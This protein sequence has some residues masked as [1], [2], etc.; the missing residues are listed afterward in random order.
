MCSSSYISKVVA[1]L[2]VCLMLFACGSRKS[3]V[4]PSR[5]YC[6]E[7]ATSAKSD[8]KMAEYLAR[9]MQ[10]R[11]D[12]KILVS[13]ATEPDHYYVS[14]HVGDDFGGDYAI[15][16]NKNSCALSARDE[17]IMTWLLYQFIK[18]EG[19]AHG[20]RVDDLPPSILPDHDTVYT[21]PFE[22]RDI[23]MPIN[24]N[25]D[26][27]HIM[28]INS[29]EIDWAIWGHQMARVLGSNGDSNYGYH[30]LNQELFAQSG[31]ITHT[32]QFCFSSDKLFDL[33]VQYIT[34]Q[35]GDGS[36]H[37]CRFTIGPNDNSI[38]C[39]CRACQAIGNTRRNATPAVTRFVEKLAMRFPKHMFFIP[40]YSTTF[41]VPDHRLPDNVGVFLSAIDYPRAA[42][43]SESPKAQLFFK[44]LDEWKEVTNTVYI[45][46]YICNFDDYLTPYPILYV[47]QQRLREYRD[48]G[49]KGI[50]LN[51]SGY[52]YSTLQEA[53]TFILADLLINPDVD[54][55]PIIRKYF[56]DA[57]PNIGQYISE[58]FLVMERLAWERGKELP[59]YGG[60]E[61]AFDSYL[62]ESVYRDM[63][64]KF[65][66]LANR[67]MTHRE[68]VIYEKTGQI[69]S[70]SYLEACRLYGLKEGGYAIKTDKGWEVKPQV[71]AALQNLKKTFTEDDMFILTGNDR[72]SMDHMDRINEEGVYIA[73]Y[74]TEC[75]TWLDYKTWNNDNIIGVPLT[76][77]AIRG[78]VVTDKLTDGVI[79]ISQNYHWGWQ[80]YPQARLTIELPAESLRGA[81]EIVL[82]FLNYERHRMAPPAEVELW[83][84]GNL[85][86]TF[87]RESLADWFDEGEKVVYRARISLP[88][89]NQAELRFS[90]SRSHAPYFAIDEIVIQ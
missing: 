38:A 65:F 8:N 88:P 66:S 14:V 22:Y 2:C 59:L 37:P 47:M 80:I 60:I 3:A 29:L 46:D 26:M 10:A 78:D 28:G 85:E 82:G 23:Y 18:R 42:N 11:S 30:N 53:Y 24:Q 44:R 68:R 56:D 84:D 9:H 61:D 89:V 86:A 55:E 71:L 15:E 31:G 32:E 41:S 4:K 87:H 19:D 64:D 72:A 17:R 36:D 7:G 20:L 13:E 79:G 21:F 35:F 58:V 77:H 27:T 12:A 62:T 74:E 76:V 73:D 90:R 75:E 48:R 33:T 51:G 70:Y 81:S 5:Y 43:N 34:E 6:I 50:F 63:Y 54:I 57:M 52:Y 45:W 67:T 49:V 25:P 16:S 1:G 39:E 69:V 83:C 40:G